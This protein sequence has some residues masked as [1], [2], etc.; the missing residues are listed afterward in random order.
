MNIIFDL[1]GVVVRWHPEAFIAETFDDPEVRKVVYAEFVG[2]ADWLELDRGTLAPEDAVERAAKRSGLSSLELDRL[3][4][5][6]PSRLTAISDSVDLLYRLKAQGH[7]LYCLS[8]MHLASIEYLERIYDFFSV[9][10]GKVISCRLNL[11]KPEPMIYVHLLQTYKLIAADTVFIDDVEQNLIPAR[12][13]G[14]RTIQFENSV[15]C[16]SE[17]AALGCFLPS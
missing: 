17:L 4:R 6:L 15:Q 13:L 1:G 16:A 8:N 10:D 12:Q 5:R 7:A 3:L 11:C 2:H 14:M 9:F